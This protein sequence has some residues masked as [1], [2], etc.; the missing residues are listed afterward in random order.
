MLNKYPIRY[1]QTNNPPQKDERNDSTLTLSPCLL[2]CAIKVIIN[3]FNPS[4]GPVS[5]SVSFPLCSAA[6][7]WAFASGGSAWTPGAAGASGS[8]GSLDSGASRAATG[9]SPVQTQHHHPLHEAQVD[10][11]ALEA[12]LQGWRWRGGHE[13]GGKSPR[14]VQV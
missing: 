2:T 9:S 14:Y 1:S 10:S 5:S 6:G 12:R 8:R 7:G 11:Y 4:F 3:I 13:P